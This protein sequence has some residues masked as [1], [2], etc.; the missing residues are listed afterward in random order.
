M[1][2]GGREGGGGCLHPIDNEVWEGVG[3]NK[4]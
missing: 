3:M 2:E 1:Q 4:G